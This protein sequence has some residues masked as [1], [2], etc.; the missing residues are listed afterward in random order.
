MV[1]VGLLLILV[2]AVTTSLEF[3]MVE[4][5]YRRYSSRSTLVVSG[6]S[7]LYPTLGLIG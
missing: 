5:L 7:S 6:V 3:T 1:E 2:H 4:L